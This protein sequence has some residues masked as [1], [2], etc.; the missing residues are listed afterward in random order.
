MCQNKLLEQIALLK[1]GPVGSKP[2]LSSWQLGKICLDNL[3][4]PPPQVLA[5]RMINHLNFGSR[6]D[7]EITVCKLL[8]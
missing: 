7:M 1:E 2:I 6:S 8:T 5:V 3:A 4:L